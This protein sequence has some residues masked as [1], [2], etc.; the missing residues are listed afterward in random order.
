MR[1]PWCYHAYNWL[2]FHLCTRIHINSGI[3]SH[4]KKSVKI[5]SGTTD[6]FFWYRFWYQFL[7]LEKYRNFSDF[8]FCFLL[9]RIMMNGLAPMWKRT[10]IFKQ[11]YF[12]NFLLLVLDLNYKLIVNRL[13]MLHKYNDIF[14]K[15]FQIFATF[16]LSKTLRKFNFLIWL[17]L[18]NE[19]VFQFNQRKKKSL[20][21]FYRK[22]K[23]KPISFFFFPRE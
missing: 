21:F 11:I 7:Y 17:Y 2:K 22:W 5:Y 9:I 10:N 6:I 1:Q 3:N 12:K 20:F 13:T 16:H 8:R 19:Q 15:I 18:L 4:R 23:L 14:R